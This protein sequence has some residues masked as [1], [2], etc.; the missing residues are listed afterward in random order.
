MVRV[1]FYIIVIYKAHYFELTNLYDTAA[2]MCES[3]KNSPNFIS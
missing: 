1:P 2:G 3:N